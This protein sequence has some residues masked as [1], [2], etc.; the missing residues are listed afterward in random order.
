MTIPRD[1]DYP[2]LVAWLRLAGSNNA[3][4][5]G[6]VHTG[7]LQLQQIP[8]EYA[9]YLIWLRDTA[10]ERY[11]A[12]GIGNGGSF[13]LECMFARPKY[14]FAVDNLSYTGWTEQRREDID[15]RIESL[16]VAGV[17]AIFI[18]GDSKRILPEIGFEFDV[19]FI[20]GDH[21]YEG[22]KAD[23]EAVVSTYKVF[24]DIASAQCPGVVR[25]W[26]EIR[27]KAAHTFIHGDKCGI[28]IVR[29]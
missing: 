10:P 21:S 20:D 1:T 24:H 2:T 13:W 8:E 5:F 22:V 14:A 9:H 28:G 26:N 23:S 12:V 11:L 27:D 29:S 4:H 16:R 17:E 3:A 25:Y 15:A 19:A 7:G 6:T 18:E